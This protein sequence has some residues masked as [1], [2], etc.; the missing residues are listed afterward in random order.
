MDVRDLQTLEDFAHV[1]DLQRRVWGEGYDD[2]VPVSIFAV[3]VKRGGILV[4]AFDSGQLAAFVFSWPGLKKGRISQWSHMLGVDDAHRKSGIGARL[5]LVQRE[6]ALAQG[7]DLIEWTYDPLQA[8]NAHLNFARL[9]VVAEEYLENVYGMSGS[10]LHA[11]APTDRFIAA[12]KISTPHVERRIANA[13]GMPIL[14]DASLADV[15]VLNGAI[16]KDGWWTPTGAPE[17]TREDDRLFVEIPPRFGE[18]LPQAPALALEWRHVTRAIFTSYMRRG[19]R[20]VDF[21]LNRETYGG[22]YLLEKIKGE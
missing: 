7:L 13:A 17:L 11:G 1:V 14:R 3:V 21:L 15:P 2:V 8:P 18:M 20:V 22:R 12:W 6:R 19:Y 9:G 10:A 5:K 16:L 4:G